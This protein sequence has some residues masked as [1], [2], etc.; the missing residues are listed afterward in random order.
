[1]ITKVNEYKLLLEYNELPSSLQIDDNVV[2]VPMFW[3]QT[4]MGIADDKRYG[5]VV[6][7]KFTKSKVFYDVLDD[8][9]GKIFIEVDSAKVWR[10]KQLNITD[11][12]E[13]QGS[14][15]IED[16][17]SE[18]QNNENM[19]TTIN[20][21]RKVNEGFAF[22]ARDPK[23]MPSH[24][25]MKQNWEFS[26]SIVNYLLDQNGPSTLEELE[27]Q[28][29]SLGDVKKQL[30]TLIHFGSV[31]LEDGTYMPTPQSRHIYKDPFPE[32]TEQKQFGF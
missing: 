11:L 8:Y 19:I 14:A 22:G 2:F 17:A 26:R 13:P 6:N 5:K 21:F 25:E 16:I 30:D 31:N 28:F 9:Y 18:I 3:Q 27:M 15:E 7:I 23:D 32:Y 10:P 4:E 1:M 24:E 29:G 20:E 12:V